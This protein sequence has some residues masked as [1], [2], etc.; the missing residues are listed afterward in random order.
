MVEDDVEA[1]VVD[2]DV[3]EVPILVGQAFIN[4]RDRVLIVKDGEMRLIPNDNKVIPG[5]L[6]GRRLS[7]R[8]SALAIDN[9]LLYKSVIRPT[10]TYASVAWAFAPSF[11]APWFVRN[12][13]LHREAKM[14]T[15]EEFFRETAERAFSKA[16]AHPKPLVREAVD[17]DENAGS[18]V[19]ENV[20]I[21]ITPCPNLQ[22]NLI[23]Y[24]YSVSQWCID[25]TAVEENAGPKYNHVIE[26]KSTKAWA[27]QK[28][29]EAWE[30]IAEKFNCLAE[31]GARTAE[32]LNFF[33]RILSETRAK[34]WHRSIK[35]NMKPE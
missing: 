16:E 30:E 35:K 31:S 13:Q 10:M 20:E 1:Y 34:E 33:M 12:N 24:Y 27:V 9:K 8:R 26:D 18:K 11:N 15:M 29:A 23:P 5:L 3:Q 4:G 17:Y 2:D 22:H 14:P 7:C 28:K 25:R 21:N 19:E 6:R 32:Q